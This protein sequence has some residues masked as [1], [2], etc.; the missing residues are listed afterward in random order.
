[1]DNLRNRVL[2]NALLF[3]LSLN[4]VII[5]EAQENVRPMNNVN[6]N[7]LG[8]ASN[9]SVTYE[10][11]ITVNEYVFISAAAG[12][13]YGRELQL[14][15]DSSNLNGPPRYLTFPHHL[16]VNI[17]KSRTFLE[18]GAGG[19]F[20]AGDVYPHYLLY[21]IAGFRFQPLSGGNMK[22]RV[23]GNFFLGNHDNFRNVFFTPFGLSL[24][25]CFY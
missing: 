6:L 16:S 18:I 5:A 12:A 25:Y 23:F 3:I 7:L 24:G 22:V 10:R 14:G 9:V 19:T 20:I 8:Q 1:M 15:V 11:L 2:N 4:S 21:P 17:G 13:G